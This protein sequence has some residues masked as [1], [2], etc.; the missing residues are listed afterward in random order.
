[1]SGAGTLS[2][3]W[4]PSMKFIDRAFALTIIVFL[5]GACGSSA[6]DSFTHRKIVGHPH[7]SIE[8][9]GSTADSEPSG[10]PCD[11]LVDL[12]EQLGSGCSVI[13]LSIRSCQDRMGASPYGP[14]AFHLLELLH[15]RSCVPHW[16]LFLWV[17]SFN[18]MGY[19]RD[20][21]YPL[22][23]LHCSNSRAYLN[24]VSCWSVSLSH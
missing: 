6:S 23:D 9:V 3:L 11:F 24:L 10:E 17:T 8:N 1:M 18:C 15:V 22:S 5:A 21:T 14:K 20:E 2:Y 7:A 4:F 16:L 19:G 13:R 12:L